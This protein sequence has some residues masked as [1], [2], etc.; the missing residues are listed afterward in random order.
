MDKRQVIYQE[1]ESE[2]KYQDEKWG[3]PEQDDNEQ[4]AE[5][6]LKHILEY[7]QG[8]GRAREYDLRT[9]AVKTAALAV[10]LIEKLD[11]NEERLRE[12]LSRGPQVTAS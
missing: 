2:R 3:G 10:A 5:D 1:V 9:R 12:L 11:R 6:F 4:S 7:S 8:L